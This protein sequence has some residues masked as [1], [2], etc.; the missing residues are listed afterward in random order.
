[1][2][3]PEELPVKE[4]LEL[5]EFLNKSFEQKAVIILNKSFHGIASSE[6]LRQLKQNIESSSATINNEKYLEHLILKTSEEE[7]FETQ[8]EKAASKFLRVKHFYK[9]ASV[10]LYKSA[11]EKLSE[12]LDA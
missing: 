3:L 5:S 1:M 8:L 4:S 12:V 6:E 10:E 2:A 7:G 9:P 11:G